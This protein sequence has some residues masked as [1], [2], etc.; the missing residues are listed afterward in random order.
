MYVNKYR[1]LYTY[2]FLKN[3]VHSNIKRYILILMFQ[4]LTPFLMVKPHKC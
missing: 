4:C 2:S 3:S 1:Y